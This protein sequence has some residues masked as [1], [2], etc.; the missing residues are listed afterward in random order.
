MLGAVK[1]LLRSLGVDTRAL[2]QDLSARSIRAAV[3]EQGLSDLCRRLRDIWPD[4]GDQYTGAFDPV[5]YGRYWE[6]KMRGAHAFQMRCTMDALDAVG[7][8]GLVVADIGDASGNHATYIKALAKP[9]Q[10]ARVVSV[11]L[12]PVAVDKVRAKGGEA[13]LCRAEDLDLDEIRPDLFVSFETVEH[14][15]DPLR[16]LHALAT[17]GSA[18]HL[19]MTVPYR[20]RSRFGGDL[21]RGDLPARMTAE[22]VHFFELSPGDWQLLAR[23][24]GY[25]TVFS[26]IYLQYPRYAPLRVMAPLWRRLDHEGFLALFLRRDLAMAE[27]YADW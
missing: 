16:F 13:V 11:N 7:G 15:S 4:L 27:R 6:W 18:D 2:Y 20:R 3:R 8:D 22:E 24:A 21:L 17:G 12:D 19:L 9:G 1:T 23:F 26:R 14:L 10:V 25:A 5:E